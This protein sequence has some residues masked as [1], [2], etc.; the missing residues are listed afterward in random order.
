M[1]GSREEGG[2]NEEDSLRGLKTNT[3]QGE[4]FL[5]IIEIFLEFILI[6]DKLALKLTVISLTKFTRAPISSRSH[7]I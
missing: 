3:F 2:G 7:F 6:L 4:Y 5:R 1:E